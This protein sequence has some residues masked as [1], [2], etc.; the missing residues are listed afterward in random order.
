VAQ[1]QTLVMRLQQAIQVNH[2]PSEPLFGSSAPAVEGS[3]ASLPLLLVIDDDLALTQQLQTAGKTGGIQVE[4]ATQI[5]EARHKI[6]QRLPDA[7][8]LNLAFPNTFWEGLGLLQDL[9][10]QFPHLPVLVLT[11]QDG[12]SDRLQ[13]ARHGGRTLISKTTPAPQVWELVR[14][15]LEHTLSAP[16][17]VLAVD[18][19]PLILQLLQQT[20]QP[21]N[22]F[23]TPLNHPQEFWSVL[24]STRPDMLILDV[25]MPHINGLELCQVIRSDRGWDGL[26]ILFLT[27]CKD[28]DTIQRLYRIGA[29]D[30]VTKPFSGTDVMTRIYN[31]LE[32]NHRLQTLINLEH[33]PL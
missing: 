30:Y 7:V 5:A 11:L 21:P 3:P 24:A 15:A 28:S 8:V 29:D 23:L 13:V 25:D 19:D 14:L 22:F 12:F 27:A 33:R 4:V 20:L 10:H 1:L 26:P 2:C 18:D 9:S 16:I 32:R 17:R 6:A 31:R